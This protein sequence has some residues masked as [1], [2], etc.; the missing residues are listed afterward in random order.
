MKPVRLLLQAIGLVTV[1]AVLVGIVGFLSI[2][3][4]LQYED[5]PERADFIFPLAGDGHRLIKAA[6]LYRRALAPRILLSNDRVGP[7]TR[8]QRLAVELGYPLVD[9]FEFRLRL[10][11]H[12]GVPRAAIS[13]F[14]DDLVSTAEE[15]EALHRYWGGR[16]ATGILVTSPYQSRRAKII[17]AREMPH[18]R[19]LVVWP[20]ER[21][22]SSR[23]WRDRES[24]ELV[25]ME[26]AKLLFYLAGGVFRGTA[27]PAQ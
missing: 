27:A 17:F 4:W 22:L 2:A 18:V 15:A 8:L 12:L 14:G 10:L 24:A 6:E 25:V 11:E 16:P 9:P 23:W 5:A 19:W 21:Q 7:P 1:L 20:P 3:P 26:S 13:A